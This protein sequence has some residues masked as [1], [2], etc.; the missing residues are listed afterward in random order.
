MKT[1]REKL[2]ALRDFV[3]E[4]FH[5]ITRGTIY[6]GEV[7]TF[8]ITESHDFYEFGIGNF[9]EKIS[10]LVT[11]NKFRI[12]A[13]DDVVLNFDVDNFIMEFKASLNISTEK[14]I[15]AREQEE[16]EEKREK[17]KEIKGE[18]KDLQS[19]PSK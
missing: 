10:V 4:N 6:V 2:I 1:P 16:I 11:Y 7:S 9:E 17:I 12:E 5:I 18:I 15:E 3:L 8:Y 14:E 19:S 13:A